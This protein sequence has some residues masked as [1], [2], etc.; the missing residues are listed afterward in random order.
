MRGTLLSSV[1]FL[2][3]NHQLPVRS[4]VI[5]E[6]PQC[7]QNCI[8]DRN[9]SC[10]EDSISC[11][12]EISRG[13]LLADIV[14]CVKQNCQDDLNPD[15]LV[16]PL[17]VACDAVGE[18]I[19]SAA[20]ASAESAAQT[21]LPTVTSTS[22]QSVIIVTTTDGGLAGIST[23]TAGG[24]TTAEVTESVTG[25]NG[26]TYAVVVPVIIE[27]STTI[28]GTPSVVASGFLTTS[29]H[30]HPVP[31]G[32]LGNPSD[33][34]VVVQTSSPTLEAT[35]TTVPVAT[36][37]VTTPSTSFSTL[38]IST[39]ATTTSDGAAATTAGNGS[40]FNMQSSGSHL[41]E[42]TSLMLISGF[43]VCILL[44]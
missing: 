34:T 41:K 5:A 29:T 16:T 35:T 8:N 44:L 42:A 13:S 25:S 9:F 20:I 37:P 10:A 33:T 7:W 1:A 39:T 23:V 3:V 21:V 17:E 27:P 38:T 36:I 32:T 28:Y 14:T 15:L 26:I 12:C 18:P 22:G 30:P 4:Q 6:L 40:P 43:L 24:T 11:L 31:V 19:P 2:L